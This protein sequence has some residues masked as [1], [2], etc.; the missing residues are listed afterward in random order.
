MRHSKLNELV[1]YKCL[2]ASAA[3]LK[4]WKFILAMC[5][6]PAL[7]SLVVIS[8]HPASYASVRE[9]QIVDGPAVDSIF[10]KLF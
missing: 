4:A 5:A 10:I 3:F 6:V 8:D 2:K 7:V 1:D 9:T